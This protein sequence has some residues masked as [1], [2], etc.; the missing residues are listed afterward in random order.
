MNYQ[1]DVIK[2]AEEYAFAYDPQ[3]NQYQKIEMFEYQKKLLKQF[4]KQDYTIIKQSRQVGIDTVMAVYI[5]YYLM[6]NSDKQVFAISTNTDCAINFLK[7]VKTILLYAKE[8]PAQMNQKNICLKNLSRITVS[9]AS[10]WS[11]AGRRFEIDF[12]YINNAES[13]NYCR[14]IWMA[15]GM[16]LSYK[17]NAKAILS[18]VPKFKDS[19][20]HKMWVN[21]E[22]KENNFK[23]VSVSWKD[24]PQLDENWYNAYCLRVSNNPDAIATELDGKFIKKKATKKAAINIRLEPEKKEKIL[25]R[26]KQKNISSIT[27]YIME[28]INNNLENGV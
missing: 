5:A 8:T 24:N 9:G 10:F 6:N 25:E 19:F 26:M 3:K 1:S 12:L 20:F 28:L 23:R 4:E 21:A 14:D 18:S 22:K 7:K 15:A 17:K 11:N 27:E 16:A 13:I 2:F